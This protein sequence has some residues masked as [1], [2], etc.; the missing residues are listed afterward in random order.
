[1]KRPIKNTAAPILTYA[2]KLAQAALRGFFGDPE[3]FNTLDTRHRV[4]GQMVEKVLAPGSAP[5]SVPNAVLDP[6]ITPALDESDIVKAVIALYDTFQGDEI[7]IEAGAT[8]EQRA[9]V[10]AWDRVR[11]ALQRVPREHKGERFPIA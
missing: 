2:E 7:R 9:R 1:M 10:V 3:G 5:G 6:A 11:A 4:S 8:E